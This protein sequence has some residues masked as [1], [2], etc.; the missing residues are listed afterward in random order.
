MGSRHSR[1]AE[2]L[3]LYREGS[4]QAMERMEEILQIIKGDEFALSL[5]DKLLK[6][7]EEY[8]SAVVSMESRLKTARFRLEG[9]NYRELAQT[10]DRSR[11]FAHD[12]L[13]SD[14]M[15]FNRYII[16]NFDPEIPIGGIFSK[17]PEAIRDRAAVGDW[18]DELLYAIY[19]NRPR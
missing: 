7:A 16:K 5:L 6:T 10:L 9:E 1:I 18:A 4:K 8:F 3:H 19:Q 15:I 2:V 11:K 14:L 12:A 13:I 17:N